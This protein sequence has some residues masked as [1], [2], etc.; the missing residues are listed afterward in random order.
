[1]QTADS[2]VIT[3]RDPLPNAMQTLSRILVL[4]IPFAF[5]ALITSALNL[6]KVALLARAP[7]TGALHILSLQQPSFILALAMMEA[8]AITAQVFS[9]RSRNNW[10]RRGTLRAVH[11]L[12]LTGIML[13][14]TVAAAGYAVAQTV[15]VSDPE[16][17]TILTYFPLFILSLVLYVVFDIY[18]GALR[19]QGKVMLGLL[20]FIGLVAID[21]GAT[22]L[23]V[24][25]FGWGFEAVLVGNLAGPAL[26]LPIIA[27][28]LRR[29]MRGGAEDSPDAPFRIRMRQLQIGVGIPV[30]SSIMVGF[31]S[32]AVVFPLLAKYGEENASAFFVLL[33]YRIAFMIPAIAIGSAIAILVN[34]MAEE[35]QGRQRLRYLCIGVPTMLFGY[36]V[37]TFFLPQW[38]APLDLLV[39]SQSA[40]LR[41]AT[42]A[43]FA[44]LLITFFLVSAAVMLQ[45]ILEQLGRGVHVL[46]IIFLVESATCAGVVWAATQ[47]AGM[48][49]ILDI[50]IGAA[51]LSLALF[52][53]Q[54]LI[55]L[56]KTGSEHAL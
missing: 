46:V 33:R 12:S 42:D 2:T 39:P 41:A 45:V 37:A 23:L 44:K 34:Q 48:T 54:F 30:F 26:M 25:E 24:A 7:D 18:Y 6:G 31:I 5:G 43:M 9:A 14:G 20:P 22:Y 11:R 4:A 8:L 21:L 29:E 47:G 17:S 50:L 35:G 16:I 38:S 53:V 10:P 13:F 19:G 40:D 55:L 3:A 28:L 15:P 49:L 56:R 51:A 27:W 36:G 1:M 52:A 32:A